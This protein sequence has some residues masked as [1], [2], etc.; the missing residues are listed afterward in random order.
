MRKVLLLTAGLLS[1]IACAGDVEDVNRVQ[2][3][4]VGKADFLNTHWY[5][6]RTVV[7]A[8]E[9]MGA[10]M[11]IGTGDLFTIERV[12]WDVQE[13][14][15]YAYRDYEYIPGSDNGEYPGAD[16]YGSPVAAFPIKAHFD[17][18]KEYN[19]ETGEETNVTSENTTDRMWFERAYMRVDWSK[20]LNPRLDFILP[21]QFYQSSAVPGG[22]FY[23]HEDAATDP[24]RARIEPDKGYMDFV[25]DHYMYADPYT[26]YVEYEF[27]IYGAYNCGPGEIRVRHAFYKVDQD[28][29]AGYEPLYYPDSVALKDANGNEI[30]DPETGEV[31]R[32][33]IYDRFGYYRLEKLTWDEQRGLTESGRLFR[34]IRFNIWDKSVDAAGNT[35]PYSARSVRPIVYYTNWDFPEE[36]KETAGWVAAEWNRVYQCTVATL[37]DLPCKA[38][39]CDAS[40][41]FDNS[42]CHVPDVF[43]LRENSCSTK[44]VQNYF[45]SHEAVRTAAEA[46][47]GT[48]WP[49]ADNVSADLV[50]NWCAATEYHSRANADAFGWQQAGDPRY[51]MLN[52]IT[53]ITPSG[54]SGYGPMLGDPVSGRIVCST[55][56]VMGWTI[57]NATTRILE[58]VDYMNDEMTLTE[59]L[60][61]ADL[62]IFGLDGN[63]D[64]RANTLNADSAYMMAAGLA[65]AAEL[66]RM[67]R[68]VESYG[69]TF[70]SRMAPVENSSHFA[71]RMA[72]IRG[73]DLAKEYLVRPED[74][75]MASH[76]SWTPGA[77]VPEELW[78]QAIYPLRVRELQ[79]RR[80]RTE[81]LMRK[82]T[83]CD[84]MADLD[85]ALVNLAGRLKD[86]DR[87]ARRLE[88]KKALFR[89]VALHEIGHNVGLRHN[90]QGSFDA[91]NYQRR[92]W[93][94]QESDKSTA[95]RIADGQPEFTYSSI[96]D[97][98]G[99][100]NGDFQGLGYWDQAAVAFAYGQLLETFTDQSVVGGKELQQFIKYNDY[101]AIPAH[102]SGQDCS[103][104][105]DAGTRAACRKNGVDKMFNRSYVAWDWTKTTNITQVENIT[106]HEVP[107]MFCSDEYNHV[108][109]G[110]KTFDWGANFREVQASDYIN[111]KNYFIFSHYLR[112]RI[113]MDWDRAFMRGQLAFANT[114]N[115]YQWMY[116]YLSK[117]PQGFAQTPLYADMATAVARGLN[118]MSEVVAMPRPTKYYRCARWLTGDE[119]NKEV[120]YYTGGYLTWD[121]LVDVTLGYGPDNDPTRG[122]NEVCNMDAELELGLGAA[123]PLF[124]G[125]SEDY[126]T[127]TI[128]YLGTYWDKLAVLDM[129]T[130]PMAYFPRENLTEDFRT[131]SVS[132][133]R[134]YPEAVNDVMLGLVELDRRSLAS[135][136]NEDDACIQPRQMVGS[137]AY[138][139]DRCLNSN[140]K[141]VPALARNMQIYSIL[142][143]QAFLT[144]PLDDTLDFGKHARVALKGASEDFAAFDTVPVAERAECTL[145]EA[146]RTYRAMRTAS[147]N[148]RID[149]A[150]NF[151]SRC[152]AQV[153][154]LGAARAAYDAAQAELDATPTTDPSYNTLLLAMQAK[155]REWY[156]VDG[157]LRETEQMLRFMRQVNLIY[158]FGI[159]Y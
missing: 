52:W 3:G 106:R 67:K 124:I 4:Y 47:M 29:N 18:Q 76:G 58:Y 122:V 65:P 156:G 118:M 117:D 7:D 77:E 96:M 49:G 42:T 127:Y 90:F 82:S 78:E 143:G 51:N 115:A 99:K 119:A 86:L 25:V 39:V 151:V 129:L 94:L 108:L 9:T 112:N 134:L 34:A 12:R 91:L 68:K 57:E 95:E 88:I 21:T 107:H 35:I 71:E 98:H 64:P 73:T 140:A 128:T 148:S 84:P 1:T 83:F 146:G 142:Y 135:G 10:Y 11:S 13:N 27:D 116:L 81:K 85:G 113:T 121:P 59:V 100:V 5:Y 33:P 150:Y 139:T 40:K 79:A 144:S 60:Q 154:E 17:I 133:Y 120:T 93:D 2:P 72:R 114:I 19:P 153:G 132:L 15:L 55:A 41:S 56:N 126:L 155:R 89:A 102:L 28:E 37:Q 131:S 101:T 137:V 74:L 54:F 45:A 141:I 97:Y 32:E 110:C 69:D 136:Y 158:E 44:N 26:C 157:A 62:P 104:L 149:I 38:Q 22:D 31:A 159:G 20:N 36:L 145:P 130:Y 30:A 147:D 48:P 16:Y 23:V 75:M 111:Y 63:Y 43:V 8:P 24:Y 14:F 46:S 50:D 87:D 61:G 80:D 66:E 152:S 6:R 92:Y 109:P 53:A 70:A 105:T 125:L 138:D 103:T 123:Y